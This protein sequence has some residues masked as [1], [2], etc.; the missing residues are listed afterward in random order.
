MT[1]IFNKKKIIK[2]G[3]YPSIK[4]KEDY[5]LWLLAKFSNY[6]LY[7]LNLSLVSVN[8]DSKRFSRRKNLESLFSE[9]KILLLIIE[10][11]FILSPLA[12]LAFI[13]RTFY[14]ILPNF[15][16]FFL[17]KNFLRMKYND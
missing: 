9:F 5:A 6:K 17:T 16:Y 4:Y 10:K 1:V 11:K 12:I 13:F 7:N 3:L 15:I 14:L 8:F 2:L